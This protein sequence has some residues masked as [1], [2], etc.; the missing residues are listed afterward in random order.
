[1][2]TEGKFWSTMWTIVGTFILCLFLLGGGCYHMELKHEE[3]I[4]ASGVH[5]MVHACAHSS[6]NGSKNTLCGILLGK[7]L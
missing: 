6:E 3:T 1:M 7:G 2:D 4:V 5:P